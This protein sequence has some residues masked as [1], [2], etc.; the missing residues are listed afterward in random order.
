[1]YGMDIGQIIERRAAMVRGKRQGNV[2]A[3]SRMLEEAQLATM[4]IKP[5]DSESRFLRTPS[6]SFEFDDIAQPIGASA[7]I[8]R[9]RVAENPVIPKKVDEAVEEGLP[10]KEAVQEL[11]LEGLD[12]HYLSKLLSAGILGKKGERK[13]VPTKWAITAADDIAASRLLESVRDCSEIEE[14]LVYSNTYLDNHFEILLLP[15]RWEYEQFEAALAGQGKTAAEGGKPSI[16]EEYEPFFGRS[17]YAER[18][19]GGYY[20]ARFAVAEALYKMGKQACAVVFREIGPSYDIPVGVW[21]VRENVR[22]AFMK[23]PQKF[24]SKAEALACLAK[25]LSVP[26]KEYIKRSRVLAQSRLCEY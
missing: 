26:I 9:F 17:D 1:M 19:G 22:H 20:A 15:G 8:E 18:Q 12:V 16:S 6:F 7:P 24:E 11:F 23:Q 25:K 5:I 2:K 14:V 4:S 3:Q 21:E 13:L 10:A